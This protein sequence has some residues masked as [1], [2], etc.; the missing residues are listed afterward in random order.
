MTLVPTATV[1]HSGFEPALESNLRTEV[2]RSRRC[3]L[4][5]WRVITNSVC[6]VCSFEEI[7]MTSLTKTPV[8][9]LST[10]G[11][12]ALDSNGGA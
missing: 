1:F 4:S 5:G 10:N 9:L 11:T 3:L 12:A 6:G 8:R 2:N 7:P